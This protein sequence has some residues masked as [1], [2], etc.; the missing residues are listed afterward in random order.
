MLEARVCS[1][2]NAQ[3][4]DLLIGEFCKPYRCIPVRHS[5]R[6][7]QPRDL[8]STSSTRSHHQVAW[9][10][11]SIRPSRPAC[12]HRVW[13]RHRM[14]LSFIH[15]SVQ[16]I[17]LWKCTWKLLNHVGVKSANW[18]SIINHTQMQRLTLCSHQHWYHAIEK[19]SCIQIWVHYD[20]YIF[21][22]YCYKE[23]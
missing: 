12:R 19:S 10:T 17:F 7:V 11:S 9:C 16:V 21:Q 6:L 4:Y 18:W 8:P 1:D 5:L 20:M 22:Y 3:R 14:V 23:S 2:R 15:R 13:G